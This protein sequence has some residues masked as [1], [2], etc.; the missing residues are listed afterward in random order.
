[1]DDSLMG[2]VAGGIDLIVVRGEPTP[3]ELAAVVAV[4]AAL[5]ARAEPEPGSGS[6]PGSGSAWSSWSA[7]WPAGVWPLPRSRSAG[8]SYP[9]V[10]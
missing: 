7:P 8:R 3:E 1:M 2:D 5:R 4:V 6:G 9:N 10:L